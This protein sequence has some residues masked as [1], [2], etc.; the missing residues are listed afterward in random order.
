MFLKCLTL[1]LTLLHA[2]FAQCGTNETYASC[3]PACPKTCD[4]RTWDFACP[5][6]C[7]RGCGCPEGFV[8]HEDHCINAK[9]CPPFIRASRFSLAKPKITI[10]I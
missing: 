5:F 4:Q 9:D 3:H 2:V 10:F 8:L 6:A 1:S 7:R